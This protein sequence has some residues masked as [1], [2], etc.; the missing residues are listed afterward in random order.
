MSATRAAI[1]DQVCEDSRTIDG[2]D[3]DTLRNV[4]DGPE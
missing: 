4:M 2:V 3:R 1:R